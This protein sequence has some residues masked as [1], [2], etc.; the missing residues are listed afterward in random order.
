MSLTLVHNPSNNKC[1]E[2][3]IW[4]I[5]NDEYE[6]FKNNT[7]FPFSK[8]C[9]FLQKNCSTLYSIPYYLTLLFV[10]SV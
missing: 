10:F 7:C 4:N 5:W 2:Y 1:D 8:I 6:I 9:V 3:E